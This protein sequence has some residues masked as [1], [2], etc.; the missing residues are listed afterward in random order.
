MDNKKE[1]H[2]PGSDEASA[3][4]DA[5]TLPPYQEVSTK[6]RKRFSI[7]YTGIFMLLVFAGVAAGGI[8]LYQKQEGQNRKIMVRLDQLEAQIGGLETDRN[9]RKALRR[10]LAVFQGDTA[11]T[12]NRQGKTIRDINREIV[13]LR[14]TMQQQAFDMVEL[15]EYSAITIDDGDEK[16]AE[17]PPRPRRKNS[18][19]RSEE[20]QKYI[21][22]V[23]S[24]F[25]KFIRLA[26]EGAV[27]LWDYFSSLIKN[28][29]KS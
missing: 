28:F 23:E 2:D 12:I 24:T 7:P 4:E 29:S 1:H 5:D 11:E 22:L 20:T 26:G 18:V 15:P 6:P 3:S 25:E 19:K 13:S 17:A 8:L 10:E 27:N 14:Q 9:A 21:D 16:I